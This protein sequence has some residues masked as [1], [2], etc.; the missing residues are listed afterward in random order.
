MHDLAV[1]ILS[2]N[3]KELTR[4]CLESIYN[5]KWESDLQVI[6]VDNASSDST[7]EMVKKEFSKV[8]LIISPENLGFSRGNNLGLEA[9]DAK[10]YLFLNSD[11][12]VLPGSLDSLLKFAQ[13]SPED[14]GIIS[15]KLLNP[16]KTLQPNAG[17]LPYFGAMFNWLS[18]LD[19]IFQV[20]GITIP[21]YHQQ[22]SSFYNKS[23]VVGWVSGTAF[24][25][26]RKLVKEVGGWDKNIFMY[27]ED[28]DYCLRAQ[29][30]GFKVSWTDKA[31]IIHIGGASSKDPQYRQWL[32]EFKGL[33]YVYKKHFG[34]ISALVMRILFYFF[35]LLRMV[36]FA[37][38]G[39]G[40][41]VRTYAKIFISI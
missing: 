8:Q 15:A 4:R 37:I 10:Y 1:V 28:V 6:L 26:S 20:L 25:V 11:T 23:K 31:E 5:N 21:S 30:A 34:Q 16:D 14:Y 17:Y 18:G 36:A 7:V 29:K 22:N 27:A 13:N 40:S 35:I 41:I 3:T 2:F 38:T 19:D 24:M 39:K 32:G 12:E 33:I 9:A